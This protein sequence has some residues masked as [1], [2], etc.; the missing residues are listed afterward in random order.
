MARHCWRRV[1]GG[2][3]ATAA[4]GRGVPGAVPE[5][6]QVAFG[7]RQRWRQQQL[8]QRQ[9]AGEWVAVMVKAAGSSSGGNDD[10]GGVGMPGH[11]SCLRKLSA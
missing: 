7:G 5:G 4:W 11:R 6:W 3:V 9:A 2:V 1:C 10:D 8:K